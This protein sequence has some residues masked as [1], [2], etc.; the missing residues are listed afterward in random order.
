[1]P[2]SFDSGPAAGPATAV[3]PIGELLV[4]ALS[5]HAE[6]TAFIADGKRIRY[7]ACA[8]S[9]AQVIAL[10]DKLGLQRGDTVMQFA[11][12]TPAQWF[13]TSACQLLG[14]RSVSLPPAVRDADEQAALLTFVDAKVFVGDADF[15]EHIAR[16][17]ARATGVRHWYSHHDGGALPSLW[18]AAKA[19]KTEPLRNRADPEDIVRLGLTRGTTGPRKAVLLSARA[20]A[21]TAL[22]SL[23]DV[24]WP[25]APTVLCAEPIGG[26]FGNMV[27]PTLL[28]GGTFVLQQSFDPARYCEAITRWRPSVA[29][30][31]P[32]GVQALL[33]SPVAARTDWSSLQLLIYSGGSLPADRIQRAHAL[34][35]TLLCQVHGQ[36]ECP[37]A[38]SVLRPHEHAD[39]AVRGSL[40]VPCAGMQLSIRRE[41]GSECAP[42]EAGE[43][44]VRGPAVAS[45][46]WRLPGLSAHAWRD[47]WWHTGDRCRIDAR[48]HLRFIERLPAPPS[49][50]IDSEVYA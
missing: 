38:L 45:G 37:K 9:I 22:I 3:A 14:L 5:R 8:Q 33:D 1:M 13:V 24:V 12:N 26:G 41:D 46:Y 28:R 31:W 19:C 43:L 27:L 6:R 34:F 47:G 50:A 49:F 2:L 32:A 40:G 44:C 17:R 29:L 39:P 30:L 4:A 25:V 20:L 21:A 42:A 16:Y 35:G 18:R 10:F 11:G 48:G 36:T 15:D 23:A 7:D